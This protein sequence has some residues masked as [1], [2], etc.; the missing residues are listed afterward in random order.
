MKTQSATDYILD[1]E[2][3]IEALERVGSGGGSVLPEPL[4]ADT[5]EGNSIIDI[6]AMAYPVGSIYI[7]VVS[8][9]PNTL[10]GFGTW[11]AFGAGKTLVGLNSGDTDFDTVEETGGEKAHTLTTSEIPAHDH[12]SASLTGGW[13]HHGD[14]GGSVVRS[15]YGIVGGT[16]MS[17]V[18]RPPNTAISASSSIKSMTINATHTHTSVGGSGSHNN[19]QPYIVV[20]MWKRTA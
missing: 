20:Y 4:D 2:R 15:P 7:S 8:T 1:L 11:V 9:N 14:E 10:F 5:V 6:L 17:G 3:R 18:Y 12:G 16:S 19:L 13:S